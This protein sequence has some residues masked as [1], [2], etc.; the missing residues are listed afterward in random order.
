MKYGCST[1]T[2]SHTSNQIDLSDSN[3][4]QHLEAESRSISTGIEAHTSNRYNTFDTIPNTSEQ[5]EECMSEVIV[6]TDSTTHTFTKAHCFFGA[7][8]LQTSILSG[9]LPENNK[10]ICLDTN[11]TPVATSTPVKASKPRTVDV[12]TSPMNKSDPTIINQLLSKT[13]DQPLTHTEEE[14][15]T[16]L[17]KRKLNSDPK[18]TTVKY[19]TKGQPIVLKKVVNP[20][21]QTT[22]VKTPTKRKRTKLVKETQECVAGPSQES[23][24]KQVEVELKRIPVSRRQLICSKAGGECKVKIGKE[25]TLI[26]K[27]SLGM[28]WRQSTKCGKLLKNEK[29]VQQFS[30]TIINDLVLVIER[31]FVLDGTECEVPY[32]E[33]TTC[34]DTSFIS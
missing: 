14:I 15:A 9:C 26:M 7:S 27:E 29:S 28:S 34:Q 24:D 3:T 2:A 20:R 22:L 25:D 13:Y 33:S 21:K 5:S 18:K 4:P 19:K 8:T 6:S 12:A 17:M 16:H 10:S 31:S 1:E 32:G 23:Y 11:L 30:Q